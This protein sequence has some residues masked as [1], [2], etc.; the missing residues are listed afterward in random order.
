VIVAQRDMHPGQGNLALGETPAPYRW[1]DRYTVR[2]PRFAATTSGLRWAVGV[3]DLAS[4]ER[5]L[6]QDGRDRAVFGKLSLREGDTHLQ[7]YRY[8]NG[9]LLDAVALEGASVMPGGV[10]RVT[11]RW[12]ATALRGVPVNA[13]LQILDLAANKIAQ[14]DVALL[15]ETT[16]LGFEL[17]V[18]VAA[19][20]GVYRLLLTVY[21]PDATRGF[22]KS[23]V[24]DSAGN[25]RGE[26][27]LITPIRVR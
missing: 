9:A 14:Q 4:G 23:G 19:K 16:T 8:A 17:P 22:P 24:Y 21:E 13:S 10:L 27:L 2:V 6:L 11:T 15:P 12:R 25:F 3:Y 26:Q 1:T 18:D 20:P 5:L 7:P